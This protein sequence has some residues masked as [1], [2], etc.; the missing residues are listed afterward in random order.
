MPQ[1]LM[2]GKDGCGYCERA[3]A[4]FERRSIPYEYRDVKAPGIKNELLLKYPEASSVP[5]I[6]EQLE[7]TEQHVGGFDKLVAYLNTQGY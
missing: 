3:K 6:F 1:F 7:E 2:Y 4:E 5:Q